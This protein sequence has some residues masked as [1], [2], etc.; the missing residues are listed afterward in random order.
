M[1][2]T[3]KSFFEFN[4]IGNVGDHV[5]LFI[6]TKPKYFPSIAMRIIKSIIKKI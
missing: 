1:L 6:G 4:A 2:L 5:Y 3:V